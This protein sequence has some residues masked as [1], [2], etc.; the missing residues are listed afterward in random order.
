M[1]PLSHA[2]AEQIGT[3]ALPCSPEGHAADDDGAG[4]NPA[5]PARSVRI[6]KVSDQPPQRD[7]LNSHIAPVSPRFLG[8]SEGFVC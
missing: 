3:C 2:S 5:L 7:R 6:I 1:F 4:V 8:S